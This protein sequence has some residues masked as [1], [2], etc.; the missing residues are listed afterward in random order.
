GPVS[1]GGLPYRGRRCER[2]A[3]QA[4]W[5]M[6]SRARPG[7]RHAPMPKSPHQSRM[8]PRPLLPLTTLL[9]LLGLACGREPVDTVLEPVARLFHLE[10]TPFSA[11]GVDDQV[12]PSLGCVPSFLIASEL[13]LDHADAVLR[14]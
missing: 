4:L 12:R 3:Q 10:S 1:P 14:R 6:S 11:C 9:A 13:N 5:R 2:Q 8:I 7:A